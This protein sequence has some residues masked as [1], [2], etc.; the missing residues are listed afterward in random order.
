MQQDEKKLREV[1]SDYKREKSAL[2]DELQRLM[3]LANNK[4][5]EI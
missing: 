2:E 3:L 5:K 4:S 1:L